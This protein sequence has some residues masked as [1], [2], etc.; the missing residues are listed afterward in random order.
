MRGTEVNAKTGS[1]GV[2][3]KAH[4]ALGEGKKFHLH[5]QMRG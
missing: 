5:F 1:P 2:L 3:G 4:S